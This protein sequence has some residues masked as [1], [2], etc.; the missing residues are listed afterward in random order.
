MDVEGRWGK[1]IDHVYGFSGSPVA[2]RTRE[3]Q[4]KGR[5]DYL[6]ADV[7]KEILSLPK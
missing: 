4:N 5:T 1:L 6:I 2:E 7:E 3:R